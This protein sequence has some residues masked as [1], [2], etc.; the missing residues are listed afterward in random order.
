MS[1]M[2][3]TL[4]LKW[5]PN[6]IVPAELNVSA[7]TRNEVRVPKYYEVWTRKT[8]NRKTRQNLI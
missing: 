6:K 4:L 3:I 5:R 8:N 7:P 1:K 2:F